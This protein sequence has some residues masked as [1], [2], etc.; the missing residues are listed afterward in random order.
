[1]KRA[2]YVGVVGLP[3]VGKSTWVNY[4][5]GAKIGIT[6]NRPQT[7]RKNV[8]GILTEDDT[9]IVF[10]DSPGFIQSEKGLNS[11]LE[12]QWKQVIEEVDVLIFV[13]SLDSREESLKR[14]LKVMDSV[15]TPKFAVISKT[16]LNQKDKELRLE[17]A[18]HRRNIIFAKSRR[19]GRSEKL[20]CTRDLIKDLFPLMPEQEQFFYDPEV[21]TTQTLRDLSGEII[22]ENVF[23]FLSKEIPYETSIAVR[24]F[25][26]KPSTYVIHADVCVSKERYKKIIVGRGGETIRRIGIEARRSMERE[27]GRKIFLDLN[28]KEKKEWNKNDRGLMEFGYGGV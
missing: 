6:S 27:F 8:M 25:K 3:N 22:L 15:N 23:R 19:K 18:F 12:S 16:D 5:V 26:E 2:G 7:T 17:E 1:M 13:F 24:S 20:E 28:V 9:Q 14:C 11:F 21:Y 10:I 4:A